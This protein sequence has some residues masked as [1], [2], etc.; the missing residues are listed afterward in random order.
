MRD[1]E[2]RYQESLDFIYSFVDFSMKRH[3][4]DAHRFFKLDRMNALAALLGDPQKR[5]PCIHVA[6]TKGKGST[7]S[8]IAQALIAAGYKV[9]LY[10]SPHLVEETERIRVNGVDISKADF[11]ALA[12]KL[13]PLSAQV[14]EVTTFELFTGMAMQYFADQKVDMVVFEV[15]LG[16][17]LDATN[18]ISPLVSVITSISYD[19]VAVLGNTLTEIAFEK[20]GI[21]KPGVP[22]VIAPQTEEPLDELRRIS[23]E[24]KA[25]GVIMQQDFLTKPLSHNLH[26]Q[27][28]SLQCL[29][30]PAAYSAVS[31]AKK[32]QLFEIPLLGLHQVQNASTAFAA[33][34]IV[35][36]KGFK[37]SLAQIRRGFREVIWPTRF[38]LV[39]EK[40]PIV[41]D[42][43]HNGDSMEKLAQSLKEYFPHLPFVL[44]FGCSAD[45]QLN[46]ML[47][48]ILPN[49]E[50]VVA[51]QS[52][53]PRAKDAHELAALIAETG[54]PAEAFSLAE[55]ALAKALELAG[56]SKGILV[57]GSIFMASAARV[58][59]G[60]MGIR[61]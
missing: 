13:R 1:L 23:V 34:E 32:A 21:I 45:K 22:V 17:R 15:G 56:E 28:F 9:G 44:V 35:R 48:A 58:I 10:T 29:Q 2:S 11:V 31:M 37:I 57:T 43:A 60:Q 53:H 4:D 52:L 3:V 27:C 36:Q 61:K 24:R 6:G 33:L 5:Y 54:K 38:E 55:D 16:G 46:A 39:R 30:Q 42:S 50:R 40:P 8:F 47:E 14:K 12:E 26:S 51:T 41:L 19:H 49:A 18:I 25:P 7:A 59:L 20:G